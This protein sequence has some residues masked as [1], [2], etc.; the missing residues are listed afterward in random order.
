MISLFS[1]LCTL[2]LANVAEAACTGPPPKSL[3][4]VLSE[5]ARDDADPGG[6]RRRY[7][8]PV[9][10]FGDETVAGAMSSRMEHGLP[11]VL[12]GAPGMAAA[13]AR[14]TA[15]YLKNALGQGT[16]TQGYRFDGDYFQN[17]VLLYSAS[18]VLCKGG[19]RMVGRVGQQR[20]PC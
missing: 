16:G 5:A 19:R 1:F 7:G 20:V 3:C 2:L 17:T 9:Y 18:P 13:E 10:H 11:F 12:Q 15:S 4:D 14:W 6:P 8:I